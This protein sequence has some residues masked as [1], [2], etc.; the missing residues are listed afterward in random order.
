MIIYKETYKNWIKLCVGGIHY[1]DIDEHIFIFI[2]GKQKCC[3][4]SNV[5]ILQTEKQRKKDKFKY[6]SENS[7]L[8]F[9]LQTT[10]VTYCLKRKV[11]FVFGH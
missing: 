1:I 8:I 9:L 6:Q 2:S 4:Q 7:F 10:S 11:G 5:K 3:S